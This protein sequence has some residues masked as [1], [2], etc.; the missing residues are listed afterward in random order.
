MQNG[1]KGFFGGGVVL[2]VFIL[3]SVASSLC[4]GLNTVYLSFTYDLL[5]FYFTKVYTSLTE[6]VK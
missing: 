2:F 6:H 5:F 1:I 4:S 3:Q